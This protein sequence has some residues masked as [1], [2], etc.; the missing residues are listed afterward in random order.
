MDATAAST[1]WYGSII[2]LNLPDNQISQYWRHCDRELGPC[3]PSNTFTEPTAVEPGL[4]ALFVNYRNIYV[5]TNGSMQK[6]VEMPFS[7][8]GTGGRENPTVYDMWDTNF[9]GQMLEHFRSGSFRVPDGSSDEARMTMENL[10]AILRAALPLNIEHL[11]T[12]VVKFPDGSQVRVEVR[13]GGQVVIVPN[14]MLTPGGQALPDAD[15]LN[16]TSA[17][18]E[19]Q[20]SREPREQDWNEL[21]D[22]FRRAGIPITSSG[23]RIVRLTCTINGQ[24]VTCRGT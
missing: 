14:S 12:F 7:Y 4:A 24:T 17:A 8:I 6:E 16:T 3:G 1:S 23:G 2:V 21:L 9:R 15:Q 13:P 22:R 19:W 20:Q 11:I 10:A 5:A 18:G